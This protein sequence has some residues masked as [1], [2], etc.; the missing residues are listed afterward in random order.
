MRRPEEAA[1]VCAVVA[2]LSCACGSEK[3]T[4]TELA[5]HS[6]RRM[7]LIDAQ[8]RELLLDSGTP[9]TILSPTYLGSAT[10]IAPN[11]WDDPAGFNDGTVDLLISADL[12]G[13]DVEHG[14]VGMDLLRTRRFTWDFAGS[15]LIFGDPQSLMPSAADAHPLPV[16]MLGSGKVCI[17]EGPCTRH[18]LDRPI[19]QARFEGT[20]LTMMVDTGTRELAIFKDSL[21]ELP[22][23]DRPLRTILR[24][25]EDGTVTLS[26]AELI[27]LGDFRVTEVLIQILDVDSGVARL[28]T[29][30]GRQIDGFI[31]TGLLSQLSPTFDFE[32]GLIELHRPDTSTNQA[33]D[34]KGIGIGG[35][36]SG[37]CLIIN[38]LALGLVPDQLGVKLGDCFT[39]FGGLTPKIPDVERIFFG[40]ISTLPVGTKIPMTHRTADGEEKLL[41]PVE[42][43]IPKSQSPSIMIP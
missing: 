4:T 8:R 12:P 19:V 29:E 7:W 42:Y 3:T 18:A 39:E 43:F 9:K 1:R 34:A 20:E 38:N 27:E 2:L 35:S 14:I 15:R 24:T 16:Q 23:R 30:A 33:S 10:G 11:P 36:V 40:Q 32:S 17:A 37:D 25:T 28:R 26:R 21:A 13:S 6:D 22:A 31:S 5:K 41:I